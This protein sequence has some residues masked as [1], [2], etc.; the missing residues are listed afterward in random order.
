MKASNTVDQNLKA[1]HAFGRNAQGGAGNSGAPPQCASDELAGVPG[2][3]PINQTRHIARSRVVE[4][5][6]LPRVRLP[7]PSS[8]PK[9]ESQGAP[10][11]TKPLAVSPV[12]WDQALGLARQTCA[13]IFRDGGTPADAAHAFGI[14]GATDWDRAIA[15]IASCLC[16]GSH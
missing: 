9:S 10:P 4:R 8:P 2:R 14:A 3:A 12:Q 5:P 15:S 6:V 13:R 7:S 11:L 1:G 16:S